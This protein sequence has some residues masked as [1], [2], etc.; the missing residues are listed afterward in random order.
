MLEVQRQLSGM[1]ISETINGSLERSEEVPLLQKRLIEAILT[2]PRSTLEE[3]M[4][5][6]A[7][8]TNATRA[9]LPMISDGVV[10]VESTWR[11]AEEFP[12]TKRDSEFSHAP[13]SG[14]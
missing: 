9:A 2:L 7:C 10:G 11:E 1:K 13:L 6:T 5:H 12:K 8:L 14:N 3:E 4:P